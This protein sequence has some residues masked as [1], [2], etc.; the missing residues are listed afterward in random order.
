M[1][2]EADPYAVLGVPRGASQKE[3]QAAFRRLA[4][5]YHPD[6]NPGDKE[7]ER[8][9][10]EASAAYDILGDED[11]RGRFDRG[12]IDA[13]GAERPQRQYWQ[14]FARSRAEAGG[15]Q[16]GGG[17]AEAGGFA[18]FDDPEDI[19]SALFGAGR[20]RSGSAGRRRGEDRH[21]HLEIDFLDAV[22][23]ARPRL[24]LPDGAVIDVVIPPGTRDGQTL[25]L[26]G[27]GGAAP[28]GGEPGDA[29]IEIAVRPHPVFR[30]DG[31]DIRLDLPIS[32]AEAVLGAKVTVPLPS[33]PVAVTIPKNAGTGRVLRL[34]GK[35]VAGRDGRRGDAY[36]TLKLVLPDAPDP[37]LEAFVRGWEAGRAHDPRRGMAT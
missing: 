35:G 4:K 15:P 5:Q 27:K 31:D 23:G 30:R 17:R 37:D 33:G 20:R 10:Q 18:G 24:T 25:R 2:A 21:Y 34:K 1:M 11:K 36:L 32:L 7:A 3:I 16:A 26:R 8:R 19:L 12:E 28:A 13:S 9:F 22:N 14:D 29:F 6:L